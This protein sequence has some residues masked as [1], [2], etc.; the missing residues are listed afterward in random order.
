MKKNNIFISYS[1]YLQMT[2]KYITFAESNLNVLPNLSELLHIQ[3]LDLSDNKLNEINGDLLPP[4]LVYLKCVNNRIMKIYNLPKKL[5]CLHFSYNLVK[6]ID[7][8]PETLE[9]FIGDNNFL[10]QLPKFSN[11]LIHLQVSNNQLRKIP[12]LPSSLHYLAFYNNQINKLPELPYR[13]VVIAGYNNNI[14]L[15]PHIPPSVSK[16]VMHNNQLCK[17]CFGKDDEETR[18][19]CNTIYKLNKTFYGQKIKNWYNNI[20]QK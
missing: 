11:K 3:M 9:Y 19:R 13:L 4:N 12:K 8:I 17:I 18:K 10:K 16:I 20:S 7:N 1:Y 15:M 2:Q 5:K 6:Y 14:K